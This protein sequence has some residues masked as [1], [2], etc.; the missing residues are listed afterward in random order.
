VKLLHIL[1][2]PVEALF[3]ET[4]IFLQPVGGGFDKEWL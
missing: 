3:P 4:T 1:V 2:K